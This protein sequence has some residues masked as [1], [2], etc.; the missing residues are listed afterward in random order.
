PGARR[1]LPA[2]PEAEATVALDTLQGITVRALDWGPRLAPGETK[3][4]ALAALVPAD[5]H[6][7]FFPSF[8]SF[9]TTLDEAG[10]LGE[11]GLSAFE[12]RSS[13]ARTRERT[14]RQLALE[15]SALARTFGPLLVESVALT[16]SDPYLR[17]GSDLALYFRAKSPEA[18]HAFIAARQDAAGGRKVSGSVAG[19]EYRGVVDETR[20]LS[21]YLARVGDVIVV[22]NSLVPLE[23]LAAVA[24]GSIPALAAA[25]EYRF[26][27]QRYAL[28]SQG[29]SAFLVLP[30]D[31]IRRW[32][33]PRW[34][35]ASARI[36]RAAAALAEQHAEHLAELLAGVAAPRELG[37][38]PE[39][40]GLGALRLTPEGV[41]SAAYGT[42]D[43]LTPIAELPLAQVTPREAE[44]YRTWRAGYERAWS[45]FF[46]PIGARLSVSAKRTALDLTVM[47]L[48]LGTEYD[49]L[50]KA[51]GGPMLAPGSGDPHPESL[52]HFV[53]AIDP[54]WEQLKSLGSILGST[55]EKL[56]ADPFAWL[57]GWLAVYADEGPFWDDLLQAEDLEE[58]LDGV[59][60][61]L[62]RIPLAVEIAVRSPLKLALFMT[63][64]RAFVDG[65]APGMTNWKERVVGERRFVEIGSAGLGDEFALFYATMPTALIL[66]LHEPTLLAAMEREEGR[67]AGAALVPAAWDGSHAGLVLGARGLELLEILFESEL[68]DA[69]RRDSWR[70]LPILN[71]WRRLYPELD[72]LELHA[73][74]F[75]ERL[76]CP[77]GGNYAWN[78]EWQTMESSVFGHPGAPK[79]GIR[80]PE[81]WADLAAA[82]F[83]LE[84]ETDGLRVRAEIER[85]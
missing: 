14:E 30:D 31:A 52:V 55:A 83:A 73:R 64:L 4:D 26:F 59:Q 56:G 21:S 65:S 8:A 18:V 76:A 46:D 57:G 7:L 66:A 16:G 80:R 81:A 60:S 54:E 51:A 10:R 67:R 70:N 82:R 9:V 48:I 1:G 17:T 47:P 15:L 32:C 58:A 24:A 45:N 5:Q 61:E 53:M 36:A 62:N 19:I 85:E 11:F 41:H 78:E 72:P 23:R 22:A 13:D 40:P 33:S 39:F 3:V 69:L 27:R 38:D 77:G 6:A 74:V 68:S 71:E 29:E 44:L 50:R 20:A 84:F 12:Q 28:G 37:T 42:L 63:S 49:D 25:G 43:F 79:D 35:I 2:S 34:R 75:G